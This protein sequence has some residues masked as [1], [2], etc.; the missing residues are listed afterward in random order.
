MN[1]TP[2]SLLL[3]LA[4][5]LSGLRGRV[6]AIEEQD[7]LGAIGELQEA[8]DRIVEEVSKLQPPEEEEEESKGPGTAP[9]WAAV[10]QEQAKVLWEWLIEWCATVLHPMYALDVWRP[11]WYAHPRLRIE[12]TWL[13]AYWHWAYEKTAPPTRAAEWH[14]RWWTHVR[15]VMKRELANCGH[16]VPD[17][18]ME[19]VVPDTQDEADFSDDDMRPYVAEHVARRPLPKKKKKQPAAD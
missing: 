17:R 9:N 7:L 5:D 1:I 12:L 18:K 2:E 4:E 11:C 3:K 6:S 19:H 8:L 14:A 10:D 15:D 16:Q 13:C